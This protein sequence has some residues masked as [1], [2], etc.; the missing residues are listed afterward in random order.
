[1]VVDTESYDVL[2]G[3]DFLIKIGAIV[4]VEQSLIQVRHGLRANVEVLPLNMANLL[5]RNL[6]ALMWD[7]N[8]VLE[9]THMSG[10]SNI[11]IKI[12]YQYNPIM[13]K[14]VDAFA[15]N[16]DTDTDNGEYCDEGHHQVEQ[17]GDENEFRGIEFED[18]VLSKR[19]Q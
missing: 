11:T 10:D 2:L 15:L 12:L 19:P 17:I 8:V 16:L 3:L 13:P 14:G 1:M 6:E 7:V 5:Q 9:N 18:L 4:D